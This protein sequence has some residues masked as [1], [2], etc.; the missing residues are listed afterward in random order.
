MHDGRWSWSLCQNDIL[1]RCDWDVLPSIAVKLK[2][3]IIS[4]GCFCMFVSTGYVKLTALRMIILTTRDMYASDNVPGG[5]SVSSLETGA[6]LW[7]AFDCLC[8]AIMY[9]PCPWL[10]R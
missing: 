6:G 4:C 8:V 2:H 10:N 7:V 3:L 1:W 5:G 9:Q